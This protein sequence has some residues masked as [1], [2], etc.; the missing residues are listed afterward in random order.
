[1]KKLRPGF[2]GGVAF[3]VTGLLFTGYSLMYPYKSEIGPGSGFFPIWISGLLTV[4]AILYIYESL[5]GNDSAEDIEKGPFLKVLY[6]IMVMVAY[7]LVLPVAGF[8]LT[9]VAF[10]FALY[11]KAYKPLPNLA[12]SAVSTAVIYFLFLALGVQMPLNALGF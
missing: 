5:K 8:N 10:L 3:L 11:F 9:S 6:N 12:I 7:V 4:L 2:W 1:M